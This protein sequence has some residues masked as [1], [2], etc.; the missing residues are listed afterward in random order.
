M[1][2]TIVTQLCAL[3]HDLMTTL[4]QLPISKELLAVPQCQGCEGCHIREAWGLAQISEG[5]TRV[6]S[7]MQICG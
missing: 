2:G 7:W 6:R 1:M 3:H 5:M 4:Q